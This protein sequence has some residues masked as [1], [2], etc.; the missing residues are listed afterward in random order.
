[1]DMPR[2]EFKRRLAEGAVQYGMWLSLADP[3]ATEI[4]AGA[5]FDWLLIDG[6]HAPN[7][8]RTVLAQLQVLS[9]Y[10]VQ[11]IVRPLESDAAPIK[12]ILD[13]GAQTVLAPMVD[14]AEQARALVE[15]VRY[16]PSGRRGVA[17]A[18]ASRWGRARD[19]W[20]H[21]DDETC[22]IVQIESRA[23]LDNLEAIAAVDGVD[24]LFL[25][26]SDLGAALGHLGRSNEPA[27]V[28]TV[29]DAIRRSRSAGTPVGVLATDLAVAS[30]YIDAGASFVGVGVDTLV[31][32]QATSELVRRFRPTAD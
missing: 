22:L 13:L 29:T 16:P 7:D 30:G 14:T 3:V 31:L 5:G 18:R 28:D 9:A 1:M 20:A 17:T 24:A 6:E 26:P 4:G 27:V 23:G 12:Q 11:P 15:C 19:Y 10:P 32:A 2:N 25:G 8:V 21:A